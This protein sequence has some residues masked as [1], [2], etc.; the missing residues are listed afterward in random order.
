MATLLQLLDAFN[1]KERF[2]LFTQAVGNPEFHLG[3]EFRDDLQRAT[4]TAIPPDARAF[5]DYHLDWLH[6]AVLLSKEGPGQGPWLNTATPADGFLVSTGNQEDIDLVVAFEQGASTVIVLVEAKADTGWTNSQMA[7]KARRLRKIFG[8]EVIGADAR[9][10]PVF[11]LASPRRPAKLDVG[12]WPAW[13]LQ[14]TPTSG[15]EVAWLQLHVPPGRLKVEGCDAQ[16][17]PSRD[18]RYWRVRAVPTYD[19]ESDE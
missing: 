17:N 8:A 1:R 15:A 5:V 9:I 13:M 11:C 10:R 2:F 4:G 12:E 7:S 18:R 19:I 14:R 3:V 6:A 16:G